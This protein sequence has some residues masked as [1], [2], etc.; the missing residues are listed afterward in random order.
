M[1]KRPGAAIV[2]LLA[3][4]A[5]VEGQIQVR[6]DASD[7]I[8]PAIAREFRGAWVATVGNMDW[9]SRPGLSTAQ[10]K[11]ELV[12]ILD[13]AAGMHLNAIVFQVR[14][15]GDALYDSPIEPWSEV[16]TGRMGQRPD[17]YWDP[18][19]FA[20]D[21][22]HARGLELHA[23]FNPYRAKFPAM[24]SPVSSKHVSRVHPEWIRPYGRNQLWM[25]PGLSDVRAH[26]KRV[27]LDVVRRYDI[28]AVHL[29]D[30]FYPYKETDRRGRNIEFPDAA[31]YRSYQRNGGTL[32][33]GDWRR[34]NVNTLVRELN[35]AIHEAKPWVRF[36]ISPFGIWRPGYPASVRGLDSYSEIFAD[37]RLWL[38]EGW[39]DYFAPQLY[40]A[41]DRR[42]QSYT[43]LMEWWATQ[44]VYGRN[45]WAG[46]FTSRVRD[47][48]RRQ[49][50]PAD[51][52]LNQVRLTRASSGFTGNIHFSMNV[53]MQDRDRIATRLADGL[54]IAPA[55]VPDSPW[56][57]RPTPG[58][59]T[60]T[61]RVE[62]GMSRVVLT[63]APRGN[64]PVRWWAVQSRID[65]RWF[66]AILPGTER[67]LVVP[68]DRGLPDY[69]AVKAVSRT[70]AESA[71]RVV[72]VR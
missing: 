15:A 69:V 52:V 56:L 6:K 41:L 23:W 12:A 4:S 14:P 3:A 19:A 72:R 46:N 20:V 71:P 42:E 70:E 33:L 7:T 55:L 51:E 40:W 16:L 36:G 9:P 17:P 54:Y 18:L 13:R 2:F 67:T 45:L 59:P 61:A 66:T 5:A 68:G 50:W 27:I 38:R 31:T 60:V 22:A 29:D 11:S 24:K 48:D 28:D 34:Q 21:E 35:A 65:G 25:D 43:S 32:S 8:P 63:V 47:G 1:L 64:E 37:S 49:N 57:E 10:Q 53:L 39:V 62:P 30:Y 58:S 26:A 44:N